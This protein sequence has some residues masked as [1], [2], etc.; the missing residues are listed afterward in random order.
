[1]IMWREFAHSCREQADAKSTDAGDAQALPT[2]TAHVTH[3][4]ASDDS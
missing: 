1:M 3:R 4:L 2:A